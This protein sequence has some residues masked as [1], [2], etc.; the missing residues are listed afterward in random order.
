MEYKDTFCFTYIVNTMVADGL[1]ISGVRGFAVTVLVDLI[2]WECS[3]LRIKRVK[4]PLYIHIGNDSTD[5]SAK[6]SGYKLTLRD[7][8]IEIWPLSKLILI[9][10]HN[11][12]APPDD[13]GHYR[14][15]NDGTKSLP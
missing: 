11:S 14:T 4:E 3:G 1:M 8:Y 13:Q 5:H 2:I 12:L 9:T 10:I 6:L 15:Y 7:K